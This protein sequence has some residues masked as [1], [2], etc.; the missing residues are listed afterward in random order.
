MS[1]V[2]RNCIDDPGVYISEGGVDSGVSLGAEEGDALSSST[3]IG[4]GPMVVVV[5]ASSEPKNEFGTR[6]AE[7]YGAA[8]MSS[9]EY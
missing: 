5:G 1:P 3:S 6:G 9:R 8:N 7:M 4:A 2:V